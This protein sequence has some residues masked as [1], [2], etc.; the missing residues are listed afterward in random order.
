MSDR[1]CITGQQITIATT[2]TELQ[3][4]RNSIVPNQME[5]CIYYGEKKEEHILF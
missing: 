4:A 3:V 2:G 5:T 1:M